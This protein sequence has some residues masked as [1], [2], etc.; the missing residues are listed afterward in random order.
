MVFNFTNFHIYRD[1]EGLGGLSV[2]SW[3]I[4]GKPSYPFRVDFVV[5]GAGEGGQIVVAFDPE[6]VTEDDARACAHLY[7]HALAAA[8]ADPFAPAAGCAAQHPRLRRSDAGT[9]GAGRER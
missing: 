3:W 5:R 9:G 2:R 1:L 4:R 7:R 8:V 6:L